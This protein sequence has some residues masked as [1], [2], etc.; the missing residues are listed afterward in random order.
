VVR[1]RYGLLLSQRIVLPILGLLQINQPDIGPPIRFSHHPKSLS[2]RTG[3]YPEIQDKK[4]VFIP[5]LS[6]AW[7]L[8]ELA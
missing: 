5:F 3:N 7:R 4:S 6:H 2:C 1:K 8:L